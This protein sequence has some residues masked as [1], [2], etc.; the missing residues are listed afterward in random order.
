MA[1]VIRPRYPSGLLQ[2][3]RLAVLPPAVLGRAVPDRVRRDAALPIALPESMLPV[4][5]PPMTDFRPQATGE[6]DDPR[7]PLSRAPGFEMGGTRPRRW[8]APCTAGKPTRCRNGPGSCWYYLRYLDPPNDRQF[9]DPDVERFWMAGARE[10][11]RI[12]GVDLY[13]GGVE[14]AVLHLL[15]ARFWHKV[16]F[17]LGYVST[18]EPFQR[19]YNQ[20]YILADA[21]TQPGRAVRP[22]RRGRRDRGRAVLR[23]RASPPPLRQDGQEPE[24]LRLAGRDLRVLRCRHLRMYEMAMGPLDVD[25]AMAARRHRRRLPVPAAAVAQR[26][27]TSRPASCGPRQTRCRPLTR[28]T[29]SRTGRS[30]RSRITSVNCGSTSRLRG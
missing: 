1:G 27:R 19:L 22:G 5:L 30:T 23:G 7:T 24:E 28:C 29:S 20:G 12:G 17:D 15:Y 21:F 14:H 25:R 18:P 3:A 10:D 13:I 8:A 6:S 9:V 2:A 11:D 26:R 4:E 16:L